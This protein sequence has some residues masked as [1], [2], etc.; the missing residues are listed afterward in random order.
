MDQG[1]VKRRDAGCVLLWIYTAGK[2]GQQIA[3]GIRLG[4]STMMLDHHA[5][6]RQDSHQ[7]GPGQC[8]EKGCMYRVLLAGQSVFYNM[9][10]QSVLMLHHS[11][12]LPSEADISAPPSSAGVSTRTGCCLASRCCL[13]V[14]MASTAAWAS[15]TSKCMS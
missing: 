3:P 1:S 12:S 13:Q 14:C 7:H 2:L 6:V 11:L 4:H 9:S 8:E 5:V 15:L 10:G